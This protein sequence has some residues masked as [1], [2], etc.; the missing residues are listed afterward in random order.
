VRVILAPDLQWGRL[1][2]RLD[3]WN[4]VRRVTWL[5]SERF[6]VV[7]AIDCRPVVILPA[8]WARSRGRAPLIL[9]WWDLFGGGG[10]ALERSGAVYARTVGRFEAFFEERFRLHADR[11]TVISTALLERLAGLGF[12]RK[13]ILLQRLGC[14][15]R[16][17]SPIGKDEARAALG[18]PAGAVIMC[19]VGALSPGD[20]S[21]V[22]R[23]LD[24]A[25]A[26]YTGELLTVFV[27]TALGPELPADAPGVRFVPR[28]PLDEVYRYL[29]ASDLCLLPLGDSVANRARWPSKSADYFNAG[30]PVVATRVGDL[31]GLFREHRLGYLA[32]ES[33]AEGFSDAIMQALGSPECWD[34]IGRAARGF[35]EQHLDTRVLARELLTWYAGAR[36]D[37]AAGGML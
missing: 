23:A 29:G 8:L 25:R 20:L 18:L 17:F 31:E 3:P 2:Q 26:R 15:T 24:R 14:D 21:L 28:Q 19:F 12:P 6:D 32:E 30:R 10:V 36:H 9:S 35:A 27:G 11:A 22:R 4:V 5:T 37:V 7:H 16:R 33:T 1:R 13:H 34:P